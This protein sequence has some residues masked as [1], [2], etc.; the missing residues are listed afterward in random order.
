MVQRFLQYFV[1]RT[2]FWRSV[3]YIELAEL[4]TSRMLRISALQMIG[5]FALVYM[6]QLGY[7]LQF[8]AIFWFCYFLL[9]VLMAPL[10]ALILARYGPKHGTLIS[11]LGQI[12]AVFVLIFL[13][14][15]G[16]YDLI[17]YAP[18][19]GLARSL[20]D[21]CYLVDFSKVK[22][23]E[24]AGKEL[25]IMQMFERVMTSLA[26]LMGG[27]V[28]LFFGPQAM[29]I[30]GAVL[31]GIAAIPLLLSAEPVKIRQK[32]TLRHFNWKIAWRPC[33]GEIGIG[34]DNDLSAFSWNL[35]LAVVVLGTTTDAVYAQIGALSSVSMLAS[36][37]C[38]YFY[39]K[40]VDRHQGKTLLKLSVIGDTLTHL[41]RPFVSAPVQVVGINVVNEVVTTGYNLPAVRGIFD[42][43]DGLPGYRVVYMTIMGAM[44]SL[45]D[46]I[47]MGTLV[48]L[49]S[50]FPT[51]VALHLLY[52][53]LAPLILLI[54]FHTRAI[55][56]RGVLTKFIH[57]V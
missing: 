23:V 24:H 15:Y 19:A 27:V 47:V 46:T 10:V 57:R 51:K 39:G 7:T 34:I 36:I 41:T 35:F 54:L 31:L 6:Y 29:L 52:F 17:I 14:R 25:G 48:V 45:G 30:F 40:L 5:G 2:H 9:R 20:Y 37:A 38:A 50:L 28:A 53:V 49:A 3:G 22:H 12:A 26:P 4:Y 13:P 16:I 11:N 1:G 18:I 21:A 8:M 56:R 44:L 42:T 43:A 32:I 55:Y 33:L